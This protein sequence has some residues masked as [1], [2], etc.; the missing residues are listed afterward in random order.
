VEYRLLLR[1][2][3]AHARLLP[4]AHALGLVDADRLARFASEQSRLND[5][6]IRLART[7]A[8]AAPRLAEAWSGRGLEA[9][10]ENPTLEELL[11]RPEVDY[12]LLIAGG[13]ATAALDPA[14]RRRVE[15]EIKLAGYISRQVAEVAE[16]KK[17]ETVPIP[18]DFIYTGLP[19]LSLE[20]TER[21]SAVRPVTLGQASRIPGLT[22]AAITVLQL[23]IKRGLL[24]KD[25]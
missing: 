6:K 16:F 7:R 8:S 19:G 15:I 20:A 3:N 13:A 21:L 23:H 2:D 5:E 11:R 9:W 10:Q 14:V 4:K 17:L 22:P 25:A 1:E 18:S 24:A 12:D